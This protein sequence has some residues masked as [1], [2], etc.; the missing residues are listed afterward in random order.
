MFLVMVTISI[1]KIKSGLCGFR[2]TSNVDAMH[3]NLTLSESSW[4]THRLLNITAKYLFLAF[5][6]G[7]KLGRRRWGRNVERVFENRMSRRI[8]GPKKDE[9]TGEWWKLHNE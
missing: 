6:M 8:F 7:V 4:N 3:Y 2:V 1:I 5:Y 9:V